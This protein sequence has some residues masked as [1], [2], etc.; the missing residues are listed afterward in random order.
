M[1]AITAKSTRSSRRLG[2]ILNYGTLVIMLIAFMSL[3]RLSINVPIITIGIIAALF[4][5]ISFINLHIK[6]RLWKFVHTKIENLDERQIQVTL[7]SSRHSYTIFSIVCLSFFLVYEL[8]KEL[9]PGGIDLPLIPIIAALIYLAHTL[10][11]S[12]IAWTEKEV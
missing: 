2:V 10:P 8:L 12:I 7:Q 11:S 1:N 4:F 3:A 9:L 6:T 5:V